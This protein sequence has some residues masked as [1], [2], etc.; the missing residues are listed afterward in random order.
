MNHSDHTVGGSKSQ[1]VRRVKALPYI[2]IRPGLLDPKH[3]RAIGSCPLFLLLHLF[4]TADWLSGVVRD[5]TDRSAGAALG[6]S[7]WTIRKYRRHLEEAGYIQS[8]PTPLGQKLTISN[9]KDPRIVA[10]RTAE[11]G[12]EGGTEGGMMRAA[13]SMRSI[14]SVVAGAAASPLFSENVE[15]LESFFIGEPKRSALARLEKMTPDLIKAWHAELA[16]RDRGEAVA[17]GLL[18]SRLESGE[19]PPKR[20]AAQSWA[21]Q[22][23]FSVRDN[24]I[25]KRSLGLRSIEAVIAY[26]LKCE[27][28]DL[29]NEVKRQWAMQRAHSTLEVRS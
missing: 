14:E 21:E 19:A 16:N 27:K 18:I 9:W 22:G 4:D 11:G 10:T 13:P 26:C 5:Y 6:L 20:E 3:V 15:T 17:P 12:T 25:I 7:V 8:Q 28:P 29:I 2:K 1:V 23:A 24:I